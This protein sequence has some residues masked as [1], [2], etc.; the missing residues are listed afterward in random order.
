MCRRLESNFTKA[1]SGFVQQIPQ[2]K[3]VV[4]Y[5]TV[6][7]YFGKFLD[8]ADT[9]Q[10]INDFDSSVKYIHQF[11]SREAPGEAFASNFKVGKS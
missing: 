9:T 8:V 11:L 1:V 4:D 6:H 3:R 10:I 5:R 2:P 7:Y